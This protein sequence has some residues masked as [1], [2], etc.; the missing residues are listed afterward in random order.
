[1]KQQLEIELTL[2][3]AESEEAQQNQSRGEARSHIE[4]TADGHS[5]RSDHEKGCGG[6]E[7]GDQIPAI[8]QDGASADEADAGNDLGGNARVVADVLD[9]E[10][11]GEQSEQG[12]ANADK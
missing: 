4:A 8:V 3:M 7:A 5:N 1:M 11:I 10:F 6:S 12:R 9:G 2:N